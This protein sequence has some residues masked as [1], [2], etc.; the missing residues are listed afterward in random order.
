[1][2]EAIWT[3]KKKKKKKRRNPPTMQDRSKGKILTV[4]SLRNLEIRWNCRTPT[5]NYN[6]VL[7][8]LRN[9]TCESTITTTTKPNRI[10][11]T[12]TT[13]NTRAAMGRREFDNNNKT[14]LFREIEWERT[15]SRT[16]GEK[17]RRRDAKRYFEICCCCWSDSKRGGPTPQ[18]LVEKT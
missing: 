9:I 16:D 6:D 7:I 5:K 3:K 15:K 13:S 14:R 17:E 2:E 12:T 11:I 18:V 1:M 10:K 8:E 4:R